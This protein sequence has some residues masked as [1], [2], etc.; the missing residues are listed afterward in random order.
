MSTLLKWFI[1]ECGIK[2]L[3]EINMANE[4]EFYFYDC[5]YC[6]ALLKQSDRRYV[7]DSDWVH[8][9]CWG[10]N[11]DDCPYYRNKSD[12]TSSSGGCYLTSACANAKKLPD[13]CH[14]L[15]TLRK[16]RDDYIKSLPTGIDDIKHYYLVAPLIVD[17]ISLCSEPQKLWENIYDELV[18]PCITLIEKGCFHEAYDRYKAYTLALE[19]KY[20]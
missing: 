9:Y 17:R 16:F 6:C 14:E 11:Y 19:K 8:R 12:L 13:D 10:Y 4:C 20:L 5:D 7:V 3:K 2:I 15:Q 18:I 1:T